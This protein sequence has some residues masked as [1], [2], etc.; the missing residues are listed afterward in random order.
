VPDDRVG[1]PPGYHVQN[2]RVR[3]EIGTAA[4][5]EEQRARWKTADR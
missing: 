3:T 2:L 1:C 5:L 4:W